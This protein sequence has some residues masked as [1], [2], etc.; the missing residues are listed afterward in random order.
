MRHRGPDNYLEF[1]FLPGLYFDFL[2]RAKIVGLVGGGTF[3]DPGTPRSNE[4]AAGVARTIDTKHFALEEIF[5]FNADGKISRSLDELEYPKIT[6]RQPLVSI[7]R[8]HRQ[9]VWHRR[10]AYCQPIQPLGCCLRR[11]RH[12]IDCIWPSH[13][14]LDCRT[15]EL[16][17]SELLLLLAWTL[18]NESLH[19]LR[20]RASRRAR[21]YPHDQ[22]CRCSQ[23]RQQRW[24]D[25]WLHH[26]RLGGGCL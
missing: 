1:F 11:S 9:D 20:P 16:C 21:L 23:W 15:T 2:P 8:R 24:C 25:Y 10:Q 18:T 13:Y 7:R 6:W 3:R 14:W 17:A 12:S 19:V 4:F 26:Q 5:S 22:H